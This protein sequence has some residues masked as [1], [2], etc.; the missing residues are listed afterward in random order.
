[1]ATLPENIPEEAVP[2]DGS[3]SGLTPQEAETLARAVAED[4]TQ[5]K[6]RKRQR[7]LVAERNMMHLDGDGEAQ[8]VDIF[9]GSRL[10]VPPNLD[11][12]IRCSTNLLR[13]ITNN[14]VSYQT[15]IPYRVVAQPAS[16]R[17]SRDKARIDTIY[18]NNVIQT[19]RVNELFAEALYMAVPYGF[20]P[21]FGQWRDDIGHDPYDPIYQ[22]TGLLPG[23]V[24]AFCGDPW[25]MVFNPGAK[26]NSIHWATYERIVPL[27]IAKK[28]FAKVA[29]VTDLKGRKDLAST[30]RFQM[31]A[32]KWISGVDAPHGTPVLSGTHNEEA[33]ALVCKETAAGVDEKYPQCRFTI[34]A[35]SGVAE[36]DV[37]AGTPVLLYDG[38][39]PAGRF[40]FVRVY[41]DQRFDDPYGYPWMTPLD[42]LQVLRNNIET[43]L[44]EGGRR[45]ARPQ[46]AMPPGSGDDD[47]FGFEEDGI[48]DFSG[49]IAPSYL[50]YPVQWMTA[51]ENR[52][53][54]VEESMFRIGGWQAASRGESNAGDAAAKVVALQRADDS[55]HG[56]ETRHIQGALA[57]F[58]QL[59]HLLTREHAGPYPIPVKTAGGEFGYMA[60]Q[61]LYADQLS[62]DPPNFQVTSG[63]SSTMEAKGQQLFNLV[64]AKGADGLPLLTTKQF[65][66]QY[67][68]L[69]VWPVETDIIDVKKQRANA[70]NY[71]IRDLCQQYKE[72]SGFDESQIHPRM[73]EQAM[74]VA[75]QEIWIQLDSIEEI[76]PDDDITINIEALSEI[77]Q[78][79]SEDRLVRKVAQKRVL[80]NHEWQR[81][82]ATP[83]GGGA[84]AGSPAQ[85]ATQPGAP[86]QSNAEQS[87]G[88]EVSDLTQ[89]AKAM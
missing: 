37:W 13:P 65:Q 57:E 11:G 58:L 34:I 16:D 20:C 69:S 3:V 86:V 12:S 44:V 19:Q 4:H 14:Y 83:Q 78:D 71:L 2:I 73:L 54:R 42:Q 89:Q 36:V 50:Q 48:V 22:E 47:S 67:P 6:Q 52:L 49:A 23:F 1:L 84:P 8:W 68:D 10:R 29:N 28:A 66:K 30:S 55:V 88:S 61:Y 75:A 53:A 27:A 51:L 9:G 80:Q 72:Q 74:E 35:L 31:T 70:I 77:T 43:L 38:P 26:R 41:S 60:Q 5:G 85:T 76:Q 62:D 25:G 45:A 81:M 39:L 82:M 24:D 56:P 32:K 21:V 79:V 63:F 87:V 59:V 7:D 64:A 15:S 33:I 46:I 40:S 17:K 18:A